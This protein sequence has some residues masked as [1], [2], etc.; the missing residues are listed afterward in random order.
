MLD[1]DRRRSVLVNVSG[2]PGGRLGLKKVHPVLLELIVFA[3]FCLSSHLSSCC[4]TDLAWW[5]GGLVISAVDDYTSGTWKTRIITEDPFAD[6]LRGF[7]CN[8]YGCC[9]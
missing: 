3:S 7:I 9:R 6:Q 1:K 4:W 2:T 8:R 5:L